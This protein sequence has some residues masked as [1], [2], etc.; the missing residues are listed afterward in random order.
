MKFHLKT[1]RPFKYF[2]KKNVQYCRMSK[3]CFQIDER[4]NYTIYRMLLMDAET[5]A[6]DV[7][8]LG[9]EENHVKL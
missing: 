3:V 7:I 8:R 4:C 9:Y 1:D 5:G 6:V 2:R